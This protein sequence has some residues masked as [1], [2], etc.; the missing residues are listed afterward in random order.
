MMKLPELGE[1]KTERQG[2]EKYY[3]TVCAFTL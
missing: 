2:G 3:S 1:M